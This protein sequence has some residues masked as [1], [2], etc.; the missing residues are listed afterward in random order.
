MKHPILLLFV[1]LATLQGI[2]QKPA[3]YTTNDVMQLYTTMQG[4][5]SAMLTDSTYV[6]LHLTP[7]WEREENPYRW[8]YLEVVKQETQDI[9]E[10]KI[11]E[12]VPHSSITFDVVVHDLKHPE[13]FVGKWGNPSFFDGYNNSILK[14]K[15]KFLFLKTKD[16]EYQTSFSRRKSLKCI[17]KGDRVHFKFAQEDQRLYLKRLLNKSSKLTEVIFFKVPND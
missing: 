8:L 16:Y 10:Q 17:P 13:V 15:S 11:V 12:I 6:T 7:I 2:A 3:A 9:V 5:Y 1:F 14:G 4:E